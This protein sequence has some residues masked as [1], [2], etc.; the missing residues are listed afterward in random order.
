MK[1]CLLNARSVKNKSSIIKDFIV[2]GNIDVASF[3]ETWLQHSD[4]I[5][6][7]LHVPRENSTGGGVG[8]LCKD[9]MHIRINTIQQFESFEYIDCSLFNIENVRSIVIYRPPLS[10]ENKLTPALF[11]EEFSV[12]LELIILFPGKLLIVG[13]FNFHVDDPNNHLARK[14]LS[15]LDSFNLHK[16]LSDPRTRTVTPWT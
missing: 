9:T 4:N 7:F 3:T 10:V 8:L 12:F 15:L 13:N 5:S 16:I 1:F 2:D 6:R 14:F 11:F